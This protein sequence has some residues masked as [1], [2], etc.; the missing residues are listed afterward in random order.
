MKRFIPSI[1]LI[2]T[3]MKRIFKFFDDLTPHPTLNRL[4]RTLCTIL[5]DYF[6]IAQ[7]HV[8]KSSSNQGRRFCTNA[9]VHC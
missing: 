5:Q 8:A 6:N 1:L 4:S 2:S 7:K 9:E 3:N